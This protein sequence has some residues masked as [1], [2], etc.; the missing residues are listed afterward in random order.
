MTC[1]WPFEQ[2]VCIYCGPT[3]FTVVAGPAHRTSTLVRA[4]DVNASTSI[5]TGELQT[6]IEI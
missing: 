1:K 3:Y 4:L 2:Q 5:S 6:L